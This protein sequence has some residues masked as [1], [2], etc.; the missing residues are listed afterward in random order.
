MALAVY[1]LYT[2]FA[3][4]QTT[5]LFLMYTELVSF[6]CVYPLVSQWHHVTYLIKESKLDGAL[7]M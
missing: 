6:S 5:W 3:A 4:K 7:F 1:C 2:F